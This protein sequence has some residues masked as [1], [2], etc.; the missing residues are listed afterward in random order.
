MPDCPY[1]SYFPD[2]S[3]KHNH[4]V[5]QDKGGTTIEKQSTKVV[6]YINCDFPYNIVYPCSATPLDLF[7]TKIRNLSRKIK[8]FK[9]HLEDISAAMTAKTNLPA[10]YRFF[11]LIT[12][13]IEVSPANESTLSLAPDVHCS[14]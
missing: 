8:I 5:P 4:P 14:K 12:V 11:N 1:F 3:I 7:F 6:V 2:V 13:S 9:L 10:D